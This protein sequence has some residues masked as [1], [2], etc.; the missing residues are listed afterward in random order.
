[1]NK[2]Q[3]EQCNLPLNGSVSIDDQL[4]IKSPNNQTGRQILPKMAIGELTNKVIN[5]LSKLEFGD[6]R[7][8]D[9][10]SLINKSKKAIKTEDKIR[11]L[12][13]AL[14]VFNK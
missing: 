6:P 7:Y 5:Q 3:I 13:Q 2:K 11:Y 1:M 14:Y 4:I 12:K 9:G 8:P 10:N